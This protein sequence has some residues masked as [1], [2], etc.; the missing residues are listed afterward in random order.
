MQIDCPTLLHQSTSDVRSDEKRLDSSFGA[1]ELF[2]DQ[3]NCGEMTYVLD[4]SDERI[5]PVYC[6]DL[7]QRIAT[8]STMRFDLGNPP[9]KT[10]R[11]REGSQ[12]LF[13]NLGFA[14]CERRA[15]SE[16]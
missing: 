11:P 12:S 16:S 9:M 2:F 14:G 5:C 7:D 13:Q 8:G 4:V 3:A 15:H 1:G 10:G 6:F